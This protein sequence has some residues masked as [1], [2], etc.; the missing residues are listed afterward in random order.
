MHRFFA[1]RLGGMATGHIIPGA[2]LRMTGFGRV[3][4]VAP[5]HCYGREGSCVSAQRTWTDLRRSSAGRLVQLPHPM[6][7]DQATFTVLFL[8]SAGEATFALLLRTRHA[9]RRSSENSPAPKINSMS[10]ANRKVNGA[11]A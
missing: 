11:A 8:G 5:D 9:S 1:P 4:F 6:F 3:G 2:W 7:S 10:E